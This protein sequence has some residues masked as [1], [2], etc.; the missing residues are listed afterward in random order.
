MP[1]ARIVL[2]KGASVSDEIPSEEKDARAGMCTPRRLEAVAESL[3]EARPEPL[4]K[5]APRRVTPC[6]I[7]VRA[8]TDMVLEA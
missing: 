3:E 8:K 5:G 6:D 7:E 2:T 1:P 4:I